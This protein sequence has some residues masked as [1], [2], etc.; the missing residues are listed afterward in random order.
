M[1]KIIA[2]LSSALILVAC[3]GVLDLTP[4]SSVSSRT[5][6]ESTHNAEYSI[7][8]LYS[9][10]WGYLSSPT[11]LGL[12]E[13]L[14][15]ELKYAS[16]NYIPNGYIPSEMSYGGSTLTASYVDVYMGKWGTLYV[17][18]RETNEAL[19]YLA[20]YGQMGAEDKLRL[21]AE[22]RL[23]RG[24][25]YFELVKRYKDVILYKEDLS[26]ITKDIAV[27]SEKDGWDLV[28]ADLDFAAENLPSREQSGGRLDK[29]IAYG[30]LTRAML[31][32]K[33]WDAVI[34]AADELATLGY[35]LE[36]NYADGVAKTLAAGNKE[37]IL[38][39]SFDYGNSITH[40]FDASFTP[41]GDYAVINKKGGGLGCPTQELVES[42]EKADGTGIPDWSPWHGSTTNNPP[43]AQLEPRFHATI[44]Y[45]GVAWKGRTLEPFVGGTD[46]WAA[47]KTDKEPKGKSIT[48][49]YLRKN[50]D[51]A[52]DVASNGGSHPFTLLRYGEVLLNKAEA[53]YRADD[54]AGANAAVRAVRARVNLP[55]TDKSGDALWKA[56]VQ[57]RKVELA[58]EG[59]RYWD[60]RRWEVAAKPWPEGLSGYRLHGLKIEQ[61]G[62]GFRYTY[63][64]IDDKDRNY[65]EKLYRFPVPE[66]ELASNGLI[67][68]YDEWK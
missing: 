51:E 12:T 10:M 40:S 38:Q 1:K 46:G 33:R 55:Y 8:H 37:A 50:V 39:Y 54:A 13:S 31:Y 21:E 22:L 60:L 34:S 16:Y 41:G 49:Y 44:L 23:L 61:D 2:V 47:W 53:C 29:G 64:T 45:N 20:A 5:M 59:L 68:Q 17:A 32:A 67:D 19:N 11:Q 14:T 52:F 42:Y 57:E 9:Y 26:A 3:S 43:Y 56:I 25:F 4:T 30:L 63:V 15:D 24:F 58:F 35:E 6:W 48:G 66:S 62:A 65:P 28:Q 36:P 27:S 18:I 7:N